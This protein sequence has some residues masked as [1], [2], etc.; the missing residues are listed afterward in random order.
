MY[1]PGYK[2][3][4]ANRYRQ[5]LEKLAAE[6][7]ATKSALIRSL[8]PEIETALASGKTCK[9]L[10]ER[11]V[12][13]GLDVSYPTFHTIVRR[14]REKS[15]QTAAQGGRKSGSPNAECSLD[16]GEIG[17]D[18]LANLRRAEESRAGFRFRGTESLKELVHG[19]RKT[20]EQNKR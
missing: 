1:T 18:P 11:L 12:R 14:A 2:M 17:H 8:L 13:E 10:W 15:K 3:S 5:T 6:P 4:M 20:H 19:G 7:P 9:Q 16:Q